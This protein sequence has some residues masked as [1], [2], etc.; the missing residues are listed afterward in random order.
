[1]KPHRPAFLEIPLLASLGV[2]LVF[3]DAMPRQGRR[4]H[5]N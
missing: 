4:T 5:P 1:M 2:V 3:I